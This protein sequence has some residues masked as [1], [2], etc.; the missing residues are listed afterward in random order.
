MAGPAGIQ[1]NA[2][3]ERALELYRSIERDYVSA[4]EAT[5]VTFAVRDEV[6]LE[7][8]DLLARLGAAGA[9]IRNGGAS[10][11]YGFLSKGCVACTSA[12]ASCTFAVSNNC[13]RD[14]FFCFNPNEKDFA[15]Y[16]EH[17]FPW[18]ENLDELAQNNVRPACLALSGG[19]P[20]LYFDE[21]CAYFERCRELFPGVHTRIYTSG[22]LLS[23][24][25]LDRL[26]AAG[27]DEI[28]F[29][30]KQSDSDEMVEKLLKFMREAVEKG[31]TVLVEMPPIPGTENKMRDLLRR[32]DDA[33]V[34]GINL[35][36]FAYAM[37]NWPVYVSLGLELRNPPARV[38]YDYTYA[39]SLPVA[40]AE[41][42]CLRLMLWGLEEGLSLG[43][44]YCSIENKHRAQVRNIDEPHASIDLRYALDYGDYFLKTGMVFGADREPVRAALEA[45]GCVDFLEDDESDSTSFHP[46]WLDLAAQVRRSDGNLIAACVST[47]VAIE[48][49]GKTS[50]R[51]LK[52]ELLA[53]SP[54]VQLEDV[55]RE[56]D[57]ATGF[58]L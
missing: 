24:E 48:R 54:P 49:D 25:K 18:R 58:G 17:E 44:H 29:S 7:A 3:L 9:R 22:D 56:S 5:G 38:C 10:V 28:R 14:C 11:S 31:F 36:E 30:V 34:H 39:G 15:Y 51:E 57:E 13:H 12:A 6:R 42:L 33:G 43:M 2:A 35:L 8:R 47:N 23:A 32:L 27:L 21:A 55:T 53:D 1:G 4:I 16:C 46:R 50:I 19:E 37:W 52:V 45:A 26:R 20:L 41:E 40:G